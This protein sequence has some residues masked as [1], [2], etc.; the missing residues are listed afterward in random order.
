MGNLSKAAASAWCLVAVLIAACGGGSSGDEDG[1]DPSPSP[2]SE[3]QA[4]RLLAQGTFGPTRAGIDAATGRTAEDW[5]QAQ[6]QLAPTSHAARCRQ[7]PSDAG[8]I[9]RNSRT[10]AWW[11][12]SLTAPD[13]LRQR[14][15]FAL[16]QIMVVSDQSDLGN[17]QEGLCQYYDILV[18]NAFGNYRTLL[19]D[20]T[21]S[22]Q[23]GRYL[24]M[25]G[26]SKPDEA[27]GRRADEN[28]AREV[29]QL[30]S[31]GLVQ[32][33]NDGSAKRDSSGEPLPAYTQTDTEN[34]ARTLTGWSWGGS[35][36]YSSP[37][38]WLDP[39][40]AFDAQHDT[41][42]KTLVGNVAV[43]AGGSATAD[44]AIALDT[45]YRHA[46]V[47]PF[48]GKQLIQKLVTSNP[49]PAYIA[50]VASAFNDDGRGVRG[51]LGAVVSAVLLD[52]EARLGLEA[53]ANFG[54]VREPLLRQTHLW[55][56]LDAVPPAGG[57]Y[58]YRGAQSEL[59]QLP[60]ASPSVFNFFSPGYVP[61]G[62]LSAANLV[63]P[64]YQ[65]TNE[66]SVARAANRIFVSLYVDYVG[67]SSSAAS[68]IKID[69]S[70]IGAYAGSI[71]ALID[72]LDTVFM[73]R[74]MPVEMHQLIATH[75]AN[76]SADNG[77]RARAQEALYLILTSPQYM[78]QQ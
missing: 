73:S 27:A 23:M 40:K 9:D 30:F 45:L 22:P 3:A 20:V 33:N 54:K 51:N 58:S 24:S 60:L 43:P 28:F 41:T 77:G 48:I 14:V 34:L 26:N 1:G 56:A 25:Q 38:N 47:G 11:Q 29:M 63:T 53:N 42:A 49:S 59:G 16:S 6:L 8:A 57:R 12:I 67:N 68:S 13:Q 15:A 65:L 76:Y 32:L 35:S 5:V 31:L 44:L 69:Y 62:E 2:L 17:S 78:V 18:R 10:D 55:R 75:V 72:E 39:M 64:E 71:D 52:R 70:R 36:G 19:Q 50:R 61:E 7:L 4:A 66:S 74:Q 21:L 37:V 46:N